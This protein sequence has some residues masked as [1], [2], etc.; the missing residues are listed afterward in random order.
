MS[1]DDLVFQHLK[2][3]DCL[4]ELH[5]GLTLGGY[6]L[7]LINGRVVRVP[8]WWNPLT[9]FRKPLWVVTYVFERDDE[10]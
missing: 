5:E 6:H 7:K 9:W 2:E 8:R 10:P 3:A 4:N 1:D